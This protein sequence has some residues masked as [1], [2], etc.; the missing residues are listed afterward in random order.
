MKE[1]I[2]SAN[3]NKYNHSASFND[4]SFIDWRQGKNKFEVNDIIYIYCTSPISA[5]QFKCVV[6]KTNM[7]HSEIRDDKEYWINELEYTK[8]LNGYFMRLRLI[9]K[10]SSTKLPLNIL[11]LYGLKAAPQGPIKVQAQL[12]RYLNEI[13]EVVYDLEFFPELIDSEI[14]LYEGVKKIITVNKYERNSIAREKCIEFHGLD[15]EVCKLNFFETYGEIGKGFIHIHH[16]KPIHQI[17]KEY[18]VNY[19]EDLIPVCPNCHCMLHR[20]INGKEPTISELKQLLK[21][22]L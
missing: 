10:I 1:W 13:F 22:S 18:I 7:I 20:K 15:C 6:E 14:E 3:P 4:Y 11:K 2:I 16:L 21:K 19:K 17:G 8:S 12:S 9:N 5:I